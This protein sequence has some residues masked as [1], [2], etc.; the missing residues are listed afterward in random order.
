MIIGVNLE[1]MFN[2][3]DKNSKR[4]NF[5]KENSNHRNDYIHQR[6]NDTYVN[7]KPNNLNYIRK[8]MR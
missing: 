6:D 4:L 5:G 3:K 8:D 1:L 7:Y 2:N